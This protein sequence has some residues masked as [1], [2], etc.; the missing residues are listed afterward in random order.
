MQSVSYGHGHHQGNF[1]GGVVDGTINTV[2]GATDRLIHILR[3]TLG[4]VIPGVK[5]M[6]DGT[7]D[8][9]DG[10]LA[11]LEAITKPILNAPQKVMKQF[12]CLSF[13]IRIDV[14]I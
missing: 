6:L 9:I 14:N 2:G 13:V 3:R 8:A 7:G 12:N 1:L 11:T 5:P 10:L 4:K